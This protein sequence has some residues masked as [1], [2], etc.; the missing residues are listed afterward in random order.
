[1]LIS[2]T[3]QEELVR[4][5]LTVHEVVLEGGWDLDG[6]LEDHLSRELVFVNKLGVTL[7]NVEVACLGCTC[8]HLEI[9]SVC[10]TACWLLHHSLS[11]WGLAAAGIFQLLDRIVGVW[12]SLACTAHLVDSILCPKPMSLA[13]IAVKADRIIK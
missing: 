13:N 2:A 8:A 1:L 12:V 4:W 5:S 7:E 6:S 9:W 11:P 3:D 10:C